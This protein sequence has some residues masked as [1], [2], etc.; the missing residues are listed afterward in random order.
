M[1]TR[2]SGSRRRRSEPPS[3]GGCAGLEVQQAL[4]DAARRIQDRGLE[5]DRE[6]LGKTGRPYRKSC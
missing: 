4:Q 2:R 1:A 6:T 5:R 3:G